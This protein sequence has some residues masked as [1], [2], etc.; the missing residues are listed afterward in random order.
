MVGGMTTLLFQ[1]HHI[2]RIYPLLLTL[3]LMLTSRQAFFQNP[4]A[5]V[6]L[7]CGQAVIT[8]R[9]DKNDVAFIKE[10]RPNALAPFGV[11][12]NTPV[13]PQPSN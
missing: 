11:P 7:L 13:I 12:W 5:P 9:G 8:F 6:R 1:T 3:V 2:M 4:G 10:V